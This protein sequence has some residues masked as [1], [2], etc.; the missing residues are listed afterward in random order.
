VQTIGVVGGGVG[1][2]EI[3]LAMQYRLQSAWARG[4]ALRVDHRPALIVP[5]QPAKVRAVLGRILVER[6]VVLHL[7]SGATAVEPGAIIAP[8]GRRIAVDRMVWATTA[9]AQPWM[10]AAGTSLRRTRLHRHRR[11]LA[12]DIAPV[13]LRRR[14]LRGAIRT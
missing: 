10:A 8:E 13:R 2:V 3:L 9:A 1:G 4:A 11:S 5:Q 14:R 6:G 12:L 7:Q